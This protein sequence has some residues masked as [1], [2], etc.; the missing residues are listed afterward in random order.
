MS[1]CSHLQIFPQVTKCIYI[2]IKMTI[3]SYPHILHPNLLPC[4]SPTS[5]NSYY[6]NSTLR[7][8]I[9]HT[10]DLLLNHLTFVNSNTIYQNMYPG[11]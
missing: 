9:P 8:L 10:Y 3:S 2:N 4:K 11:S 6:N 7:Y 5:S 1:T